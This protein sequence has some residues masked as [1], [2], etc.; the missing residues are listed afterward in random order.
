M[1][2]QWRLFATDSAED[3]VLVSSLYSAALQYQCGRVKQVKEVQ[4]LESEADGVPLSCFS[5]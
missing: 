4:L 5:C 2:S 3:A 1:L